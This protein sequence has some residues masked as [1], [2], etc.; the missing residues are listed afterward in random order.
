VNSSD[1]VTA[2]GLDTA[3]TIEAWR[4][5]GAHQLDPVRFRFIESLARRAAEHGGQTRRILED[6]LA[7]L[8]AAYSEDLGKA[9]N[10]AP[11]SSPG[12][13]SVA[14]P[15]ARPRPSLPCPSSAPRLATPTATDA[16]PGPGTLGGLVA[17][18]ARHAPSPEQGTAARSA[19][20]TL[21]PGPELKSIRYFKRTLSKLSAD[22]RLAQSLAK[23]PGNAGPLNSHHLVHRSLLLMRELSPDYLQRFIGHVDA[24]LW[25]DQVSSGQSPTAKDVARTES[26]RKPTRNKSG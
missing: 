26:D 2:A 19:S 20:P 17:H 22:Q 21:S 11:E 3:A 7:K 18:L 12:C 1:S 15:T 14:A 24:L 23:L 25:L 9:S 6:K 13:A 16:P 4:A 10:A 5:S 8:M